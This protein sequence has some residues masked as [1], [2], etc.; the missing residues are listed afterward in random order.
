VNESC[1]ETPSNK[2]FNEFLQQ[3]AKE[4]QQ[5]P[6]L[7]NQRQL[8]LS[9][10]VN[11]ILRS[12]QLIHPQK[13][14]WQ[15]N[16]YED[17]YNEALQKT[18]LEICQKIDNY[19]SNHPVMAW[20]NFLFKNYFIKVVNEREKQGI[21]YIPTIEKK[22]TTCILSLDDLD[23]SAPIEET[24]E[25]AQLLRQ[26]LE[27]DPENLL[28]NERL[29]ERP[30]VTFQFLAIAKF[31]EDRTWDD[32]ATNLGIPLQTLCSFFARRLQK[33]MP[34]FKRYLQE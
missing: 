1:D 34:Y 4:A 21:T 9:K 29:R 2:D 18:M 11:E 14:R 12:H 13:G 6:P 10:L 33:L 24:L 17:F 15:S 16:L 5:H 20:V 22:Q 7:S 3:L 8:A 27:D 25:N 19:N 32:I 26:F 28:A 31:V 23:R 30:E